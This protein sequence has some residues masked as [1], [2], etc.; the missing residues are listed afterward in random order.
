MMDLAEARRILTALGR[1]GVDYV[2]VGSMAMAAQGLVRASRDLGFFVA[3]TPANVDRVKKAL[4]SLYADDASIDEIS[5]EAFPHL[6]YRRVCAPMT[7][8]A[9]CL[10]KTTI[11]SV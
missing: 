10:S 5:A 2:L 9:C 6:P 8:C 3:P 4:K 7:M 11:R 1:E